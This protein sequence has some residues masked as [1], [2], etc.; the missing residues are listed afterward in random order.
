MAATARR[1]VQVYHSRLWLEAGLGWEAGDNPANQLGD[2][3]TAR[4]S[5]PGLRLGPRP[6]PASAR[7]E[8]WPL[9]PITLYKGLPILI[10]RGYTVGGRP[11]PPETYLEYCLKECK[12]RTTKY[13]LVDQAQRRKTLLVASKSVSGNG[14][15]WQLS[16]IIESY[17][18]LG[19]V[20]LNEKCDG[21]RGRRQDALTLESGNS[22]RIIPLV[23]AGF[24]ASP[25]GR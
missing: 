4:P 2:T 25:S 12:W 8:D 16:P 6:A 18:D 20:A 21:D 24:F 9:E 22:I 15:T 1:M 13:Q 17:I 14:R 7:Y 5:R 19:G 23:Y 10:V 3:S 11:E